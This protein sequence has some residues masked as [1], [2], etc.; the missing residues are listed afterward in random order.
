MATAIVYEALI[1]MRHNTSVPKK[2]ISSAGIGM[3]PP[4]P[5]GRPLYIEVGRLGATTMKS[6]ARR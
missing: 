4:I 1:R 6:P 2:G 5:G 3:E